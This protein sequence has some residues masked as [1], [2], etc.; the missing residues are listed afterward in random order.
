[1]RCSQSLLTIL[2]ST[3][4][5][6][7]SVSVTGVAMQPGNQVKTAEFVSYKI[8]QHKL[9]PGS[10][11]PSTITSDRSGNIWFVEQA[12]NQVG[13]YDPKADKFYEYAI[14]TQG[15]LPQG[16]SVGPDGNVW[17][18]EVQVGKLGLLP[19]GSSQIV[20][21][22]LPKG[23]SGLSCGPI[24]VTALTDAVWVTC[25]FSNQIDEFS[26]STQTFEAF[27]LPVPFSAPLQT[28]FDDRGNFWFTA[29]NAEM[30]GY[31]TTSMLVNGTSNGIQE[32]APVN[33]T[34]AYVFTNPLQSA[35]IVT[36]IRVPSQIA[37][38]PDGK[39]IWLTEHAASSFDRYT[40]STKT[41][42]KYWTSRPQDTSFPQSLPNGIAV[43]KDGVVWFT[44]HY[45]NAIA[46]F[47]PVSE[48]LSEYKIPCCNA[49]LAVTLYLTLDS[50]GSIWFSEFNGH[51]IGE[52]VAVPGIVGLSLSLSPGG[53]TLNPGGSTTFT[54]S[55]S[56]PAG[57][58][59]TD[60]ALAISGMTPS[61]ALSNLSAAFSSPDLTLTPGGNES[62]TL[63]IT[64]HGVYPGIYYLTVGGRMVADN[65]TESL[66]LELTVPG[67]R[68]GPPTTLTYALA[69]GVAASVAVVGLLSY[70][71]KRG[72]RGPSES[73]SRRLR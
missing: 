3:L 24:G 20:E 2:I 65:V 36:S 70:R 47:D 69:V 1:M 51:A 35:P 46:R 23:P 10:S 63:T 72:R 11:Q 15:A 49:S 33:Q 27:D 34:Y 25:E 40:I 21:I 18:A 50:N 54:V 8:V 32:F 4:L 19:K 17:F 48:Q 43:D 13:M 31:A 6:V 39:S 44:E 30:L 62:S 64:G 38:S 45:G 22:A 66:I 9:P 71:R 37:F 61:G 52:L 41:L 68:G 60:V 28:L 16:I 14:P 5:L 7:Q 59:Q 12:S 73:S 56:L 58:K 26:P 53:A 57:A 29:A 55:G 42:L 67:S